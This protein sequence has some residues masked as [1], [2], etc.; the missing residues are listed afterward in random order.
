MRKT[1][2]SRGLLFFCIR[3]SCLR[4][5]SD[6]TL[7]TWCCHTTVLDFF[8]LLLL[9]SIS[10]KYRLNLYGLNEWY[11]E[12][13]TSSLIFNPIQNTGFELRGWSSTYLWVQPQNQGWKSQAW[14]YNTRNPGT[15]EAETRGARDFTGQSVYPNWWASGQ[16]GVWSQRRWMGFLWMTHWDDICGLYTGDTRVSSTGKH[17]HID[18]KPLLVM[19]LTSSSLQ[20]SG[21]CVLYLT[22]ELNISSDM[23]F[24]WV[25]HI[26]SQECLDI[27]KTSSNSENSEVFLSSHPQIRKQG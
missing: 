9:V 20:T 18:F 19:R 26:I 24:F 25:F 10:Y 3:L 21:K 1:P 2:V 12:E 16:G 22:R 6:H 15:E 11:S 27:R 8:V 5:P 7:A 14:W 13:W 4:W 23:N 17:T